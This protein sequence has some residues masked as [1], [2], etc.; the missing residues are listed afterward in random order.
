[1]KMKKSWPRSVAEPGLPW[2]RH[3]RQREVPTY[4]CIWQFFAKSAWNWKNV[5]SERG[6]MSL[7]SRR[8]VNVERGPHWIRCILSSAYFERR[9]VILWREI[10]VAGWSTCRVWISRM[11]PIFSNR[12]LTGRRQEDRGNVRKIFLRYLISKLTHQLVQYS[13]RMIL[14]KW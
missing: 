7:S 8:S 13:C 11:G 14:S 1:M 4:Y 3:Q 9:L 6:R 2:R 12:Q 5:G 10:S